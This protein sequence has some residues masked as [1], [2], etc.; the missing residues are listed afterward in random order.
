MPSP[1][2]PPRRVA[3]DSVQRVNRRLMTILLPLAAASLTAGCTTFSDA[4]AV[5][6]VGDT[7]LSASELDEL[8]TEQQFP[9]EARNDLGLVRPVIS[10]WIEQTAV[11]NGLFSPEL[12]AAIPDDQLLGLY[13][14]GIGVAG[15]T[16]VRLLV[17]A[18]P[19]AGDA[20][21]ARLRSGDDFID[22]FADVNTD[23]DL[24]GVDGEAGCFDLNQFAGVE[25]QPPEIAALFTVNEANPVASSPSANADG[26]AAGLVIVHRGAAD[27]A[28]DDREQ[29]VELI[30]QV[31]GVSLVVEDL[32]V[33][34]A[35]RYGTFD[36]ASASVVPLG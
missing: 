4:D 13:G 19:E 35:S 32:D 14:Q 20:A 36:V 24:A 26:T 22:V 11:E 10:A 12:I 31:G 1:G 21:A 17:A 27:L 28:P 33:Y 34:V 16:C 15:V 25:P 5:A 9:D 23:V 29:V 18:S 8:L 2:A 6:R 30:R 3:T 7:E